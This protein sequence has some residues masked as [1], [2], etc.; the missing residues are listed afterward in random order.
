MRAR[1]VNEEVN[2]ERSQNPK[3][4]LDIGGID[5]FKN[6][7]KILDELDYEIGQSKFS[8]GEEWA[9]FLENNLIGKT[10][11]AD[12]KKL[13]GIDTKTGK[14][15]SKYESGKF[16]IKVVALKMGEEFGEM[17]D[18]YKHIGFVPQ[19]I[20]ADEDG[21]IYSISLRAGQKIYFE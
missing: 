2:F 18:Q 19:I 13:P 4:A 12:M 5:L 8:A 6:L 1:T 9:E 16:T 17:Y 14:S 21:G 7:E 15:T 20:L 11:T 10:I 3:T